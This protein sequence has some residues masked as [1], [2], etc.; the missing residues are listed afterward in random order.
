MTESTQPDSPPVEQGATGTKIE[1]SS[2]TVASGALRSEVVAM[3]DTLS[4]RIE[5]L[6]ID[7]ARMG[8]VMKESQK[9]NKQIAEENAAM[10]EKLE[11]IDDRQAAV[12]Q[13]LGESKQI[14][15]VL[16]TLIEAKL[17]MSSMV[18]IAST[19]RSGEDLH[20]KI[21]AEREYAKK[22]LRESEQSSLK[23]SEPSG[24]GLT[25]SLMGASSDLGG[26][27]VSSEDFSEM[28]SFLSGKGW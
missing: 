25:E 16:A 1:E 21:T 13:K 17:P 27:S 15:D 18:R 3:R 28:D 11:S 14:G 22:L 10:R 5:Q 8:Q 26:S 6:S 2:S 20:A 19:F 24:L 23:T 4:D 9:L 12:D 7:V